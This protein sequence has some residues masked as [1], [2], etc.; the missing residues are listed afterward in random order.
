MQSLTLNFYLNT[1][2]V[3]HFH[4]Y[5]N[6]ANTW[7]EHLELISNFISGD[8]FDWRIQTIINECANKDNLQWEGTFPYYREDLS[9]MIYIYDSRPKEGEDLQAVMDVFHKANLDVAEVS[10][11]VLKKSKEK[12]TKAENTNAKI[13][14]AM[15]ANPPLNASPDDVRIRDLAYDYGES[16]TEFAFGITATKDNDIIID[17]SIYIVFTGKNSKKSPTQTI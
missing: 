2:K 4:Y 1:N 16:N 15:A 13:L 8:V 10:A 11:H 9:F 5:Q 3:I 12:L 17:R 14:L 6:P 7:G